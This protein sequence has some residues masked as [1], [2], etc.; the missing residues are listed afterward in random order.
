MDG[1]T[2]ALTHPPICTRTCM[3]A[4]T[5]ARTHP[6]THPQI[7]MHTRTH[8]RT[9]ERTHARMDTHTNT[10]R[11]TLT[12]ELRYI[13]AYSLHSFFDFPSPSRV[14]DVYL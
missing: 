6:P 2:H 3:H 12:L 10:H 11:H 7:Q 13:T 5:H 4:R 9:D 8:A 14:L 1:G